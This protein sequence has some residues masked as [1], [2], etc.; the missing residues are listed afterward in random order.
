MRNL[1]NTLRR[2]LAMPL[3]RRVGTALAAYLVGAGVA[4]DDATAI[5]TGLI[6]VAGILMDLA[7]SY[8]DR[9]GGQ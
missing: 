7:F 1:L 6:A 5:V 4:S 3:L 9:K 8:L 2:E